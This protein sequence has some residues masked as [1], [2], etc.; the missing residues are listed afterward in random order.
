VEP[1][2]TS[3]AQVANPRSTRRRRVLSGIALVLACLSIFLATVGVWAHQVAFNTDRFTSLVGN[4]VDDPALIA[5]VSAAISTQVVDALGV[6]DRITNRLPYV[7]KSLAPA[8]PVAISDGIAAR[9]QVA[10]AR[11]QI[12]AALLKMVSFTH[13]R[14]MNLLRDNPDAV[15]VVNG[16]VTVD[17][18]PVVQAA[19]TE[20]QSIGLLPDGVQIPDL[21]TGEAPSALVQR[22]ST[23]LGVTLP[24]DF[25]TIQL[26]PADRLLAARTAVRAFDIIVVLLVV[27]SVVL[28]ALALWLARDRRRMVVYLALGTLIAFLLGRFAIDGVTDALISGIQDQGLAGGVRSVVEATVDNLR[29]VT[30][31]IVIATAIVAVVAYLWGRPRWVVALTSG[32]D[33]PAGD[34]PA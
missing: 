10:L 18:F 4:A 12:Q 33:D 20:L 7:A 16:Y 29:S 26:M 21:S 9:L 11:P 27:L 6:Q 30:I 5:P 34:V 22:L 32:K 19:L 15:S 17:V 28:V 8:L 25:G 23:A 14:I 31:V 1:T 3:A 24:A 13:A 2:T